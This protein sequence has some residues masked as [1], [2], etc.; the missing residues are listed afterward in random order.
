MQLKLTQRYAIIDSAIVWDG[1]INYLSSPKPEDTAIR[2]ES[3]E[4]AGELLELEGDAE[5]GSFS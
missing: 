3:P 2:L 5:Q 4:L 1:D